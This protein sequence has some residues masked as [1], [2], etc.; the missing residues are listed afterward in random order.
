MREESHLEKKARKE[1]QSEWKTSISKQ[2]EDV[3][4]I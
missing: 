4:K 2:K 3:K 1:K